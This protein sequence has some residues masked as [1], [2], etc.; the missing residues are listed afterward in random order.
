VEALPV[1]NCRMGAMIFGGDADD[2]PSV[3]IPTGLNSGLE[4]LVIS[5]SF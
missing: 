2:L 4:P 1:G 5:S 3:T